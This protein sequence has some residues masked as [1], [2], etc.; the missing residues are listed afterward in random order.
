MNFGLWKGTSVHYRFAFYQ[1]P[2]GWGGKEGEGKQVIKQS[3]AAGL[4]WGLHGEVCWA[5][6]RSTWFWDRV[7]AGP[8]P[9]SIGAAPSLPCTKGSCHSARGGPQHPVGRCSWRP[10]TICWGCC[11]WLR[12]FYTS[13]LVAQS[14]LTLCNPIDCS[15]P[16]SSVHGI[17]QAR[18]LEWVAISFSRGS[19]R[20]RNQTRVSCTAGI[21]FIIWATREAPVNATFF[22]KSVRAKYRSIYIR[23]NFSQ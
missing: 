12:Q 20:P 16:G 10:M 14:C 22:R 6:T 3:R 1:S 17:L 5:G 23:I 9:P 11:V 18:I 19:S 13:E 4:D 8:A 7:P 21:V 2:W 15:P